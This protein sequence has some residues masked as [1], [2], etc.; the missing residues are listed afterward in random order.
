MKKVAFLKAKNRKFLGKKEGTKNTILWVQTVIDGSNTRTLTPTALKW[1]TLSGWS[2][3]LNTGA[4]YKV[5]AVFREAPGTAQYPVARTS[6]KRSLSG[7]TSQS[8][9]GQ[10]EGA[11]IKTQRGELHGG[12]A[13]QELW[14]S[15]ENPTE[16]KLGKH[17]IWFPLTCSPT[18]S[19]CLTLGRPNC[20][21]KNKGT[22]QDRSVYQVTEQSGEWIWRYQHIKARS[23]N[24]QEKSINSVKPE[25]HSK[26]GKFS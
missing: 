6:R 22:S 2:N 10:G 1:H 12:A 8:L 21:P 20:K 14:P 11:A 19:L 26:N 15:V 18:P 13:C 17:P 3:C 16:R 25:S 9:K 5:W 7:P 24:K 23:S 4:D